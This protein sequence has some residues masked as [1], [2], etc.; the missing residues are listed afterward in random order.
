MQDILSMMNRLRRP[1]LLIRAA[2]LGAQDYDRD[3]HLRRLLGHGAPQRHGEALIHLMD[4]EKVLNGQRRA[5]DAA[6]SLTRHVDV[7]IAMLAEARL[8]R[9]SCPDGAAA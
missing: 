1:R 9:A 5:G 3:R 8:L 2:R 4:V 7:M 6:Y